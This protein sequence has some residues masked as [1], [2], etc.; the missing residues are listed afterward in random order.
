FLA[1]EF[2]AWNATALKMTKDGKTW[3]A[4]VNLAAGRY[5]YK[6]VADG[7]WIADPNAMELV[8]DPYGGNNSVLYV[9]DGP[10]GISSA[11]STPAPAAPATPAAP[12]YTGDP[13]EVT[14]SYKPLIS[15]I[16]SC[17]LVGSFDDWNQQAHPMNDEDGDGA[18]TITMTLNP[19]VYE[20]K[21][22]V[23][24]SNWLED[25]EA[26]ETLEDPYGG[27]NSVLRVGEQAR[28]K[29]ASGPGSPRH[30]EFSFTPEGNPNDVSLAGTFNNWTVG[31]VP[32]TDEDG[33]GTY[34]AT[35]LLPEGEYMYKFV[36]DGSWITD[37]SAAWFADDGFGGKNSGLTVDDSYSGIDLEIGDG[38]IFTD[39]I[40]HTQAIREVNLVSNDEVEF[41]ARA[42]AGDVEGVYLWVDEGGVTE[43]VPMEE[44][45]FDATFRYYRATLHRPDVLSA[46]V[47]YAI[48]YD[49]GDT[50]LLLSK[51][52]F[53]DP[54]S[55]DLFELSAEHVVRF[56][57]PD[58]VQ[59]GVIYQIFPDRF[60]NGDPSNDPDFSEDYYKGMTDLPPG[61]KTNGEYF[62]LVE[63]WND[64][65]GLSRS[66]YRTDGKPDYFSFYGGD[67]A[68]IR[69]HLDYL[70]DLGV[71]ILYFNPL[72]PA[73]SNH[74]YEAFDYRSIDP[75]FGTPEE[76]RAFVDE[77]HARGM[78]VVPDWVINHIGEHSPYF[79]DTVK[80]GRDSEY[81]DWF[82][83]H[84]WPL[85]ALQPADW[86]EFYECWWGFAH[87]PDLNYDLSRPAAQENNYRDVSEAD[88]NWP[89]VDYILD[90]AEWWLKDMDVDGFRLDVPNEVPFWMWGL[91]RERVREVK[92]DAYLV[93][94]LWSDASDYVAPD[95]FDA[96]M[97]YKYFKDPVVSFLGQGRMDATRFDAELRTGRLAYP[98]QAVRAMMNL[99]DSHDT[100]RYLNQVG[101]SL[102]RLRLTAL[103]QMTYVGAPHVY[104][105][106]E[107]A[108]R[109]G[110]DPDCR[111]T[112]DW[113]WKDEDERAAMHEWYRKLIHLRRDHAVFTRG[114]FT[115][116]FAEGSVYAYLRSDGDEAF[117]VVL[118]AGDR[119][120]DVDVPVE[121]VRTRFVDA[122]IDDAAEQAA[123]GGKLRVRLEPAS[124]TV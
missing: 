83:W 48:A 5:E 39:G 42:Y 102:D 106:D 104:Y 119:A 123:E 32:M 71:S 20:Y 35:L 30:V 107:I 52:G 53:T 22:L 4:T 98:V 108:I 122:L 65:S 110:A 56:R 46:G 99:V 103:F 17:H 97:N 79:Q 90:S 14:F 51:A 94:E 86:R 85:P 11:P 82:E 25:P 55:A 75:H 50:A 81:W 68:G 57:T 6:F 13:E 1:G 10:V 91:F 61:G 9:G 28:A 89:V 70:E 113:R 58:W 69:E 112:F 115:T 24:G 40:H 120:V 43:K 66:P 96:T 27:K 77:C 12:T 80:K 92:P 78:R 2:N 21:F 18:W 105:G 109:G 111:R 63:D 121:G 15:G 76:F 3:R 49:D 64:V 29:A 67:I 47:R 116:L 26:E 31:K 54:A 23:D 16:D 93:G 7:T 59:D 114:D 44:A 87:M 45:G 88:V 19:G 73:R 118:N 41:T 117:V 84:K 33:D 101:G 124:G 38:K 74:K 95:C 34:T 60:A 37:E 36:V 8:E 62:H 72:F 100:P